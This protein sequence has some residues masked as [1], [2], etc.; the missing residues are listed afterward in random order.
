MKY[1]PNSVCRLKTRIISLIALCGLL[2]V[3][4]S[5]QPTTQPTTQPSTR[6]IPA[7]VTQETVNMELSRMARQARQAET[8]GNLA[9]ALELWRSLFQKRPGDR[10]VPI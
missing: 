5:A 3:N 1:C 10:C 6:T 8:D 4:L 9:R 7:P 2:S